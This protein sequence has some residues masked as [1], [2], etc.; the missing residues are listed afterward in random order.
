MKKLSTGIIT[1][2]MALFLGACAGLFQEPNPMVG[3][4]DISIDTPV[5]AMNADLVVNE[6]LTGEMSSPDMGSAP[7]NDLSVD[8]NNVS[9]STTV[10]AQGMTITMNFNGTVEGDELNG[11]FDTDFGAISVS[12]TRQG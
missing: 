12:G 7:L 5:G 10:D 1:M 2:T 8:G 4:W 11:S 9:F 3:E 6:D